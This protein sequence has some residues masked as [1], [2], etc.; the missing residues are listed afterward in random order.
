[1]IDI[2]SI[3]VEIAA[4]AAITHIIIKK[5]ES[6]VQGTVMKRRRKN[7][8]SVDIDLLRILVPDYLSQYHF[9]NI[10]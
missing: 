2:E 4:I 3:D 7:I 10:T 8:R 1:M 6:I 9:I 5:V